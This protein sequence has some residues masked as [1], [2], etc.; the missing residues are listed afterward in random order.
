MAA[1]DGRCQRR[2][3]GCLRSPRRRGRRLVTPL[4]RTRSA[5][6]CRSRASAATT[7]SS[8]ADARRYRARSFSS[9]ARCSLRLWRRA[10]A[11]AARS[12][13]AAFR[14]RRTNVAVELLERIATETFDGLDGLDATH[15]MGHRPCM[16][17]SVP[18]IGAAAGRPG[19]WLAVGHGHLGLTDSINTAET[20]CR[21]DARQ[22]V[23]T[24][25]TKENSHARDV[26][27][28]RMLTAAAVFLAASACQAEE[29]P[30]K[31]VHFVIPFPAGGS[32]DVVGR[33]IADKL[34]QSLEAAF[35]DRKPGRCR[36]HDRLRRRGQG[37]TRRLHR[38]YR[39]EQPRRRSRRASTASC[40]TNPTRDFTPVSLI[41]TATILVVVN[42]SVPAKS[43][44]E[45]IALA[46]AKPGEL[47]FAS[48]G[49]GSVSHLT[50]EYF[51]S[52]AGVDIRHIP[53]KGDTPDDQRLD[54]PGAFRW[55]SE[56]RLHSCRR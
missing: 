6:A 45:L 1:G 4:A 17:D 13:S 18:V 32:T 3:V 11:S 38:A 36:R 5:F 27:I 56:R 2:R 39:H 31:P 41:G 29:W 30:T 48:S 25:Y 19:L 10:C 9:T 33:L 24:T 15:W 8:P 23:Q 28:V 55:R 22:A 40:R 12:K 50:G 14:G 34:S 21:C 44:R 54:Q 53:Y 42:P 49:N 43:V 20:H 35:R 47:S 51:K 37:S 7:C 52:L 16:P 46:K 26:A